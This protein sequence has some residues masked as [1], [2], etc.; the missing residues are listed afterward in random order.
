[1][2]RSLIWLAA[3]SKPTNGGWVDV[4][5]TAPRHVVTSREFDKIALWG[6]VEQKPNEDDPTKRTTGIWR[7]KLDGYEFVGLKKQIESHVLI[8]NGDVLGFSGKQIGIKDAL[9]K[10]FSYQELME[11]A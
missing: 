11:A 4:P 9:G 1:M 6:L 3:H 10:R 8:Y 2:A 7:C 5:S